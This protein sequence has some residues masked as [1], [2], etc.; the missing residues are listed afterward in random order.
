M[1]QMVSWTHIDRCRLGDLGEINLIMRLGVAQ[2]IFISIRSPSIHSNSLQFLNITI[3]SHF[4]IDTD[5]TVQWRRRVVDIEICN[6]CFDDFCKD[7]AVFLIMAN[8]YL[9]G[10]SWVE[11]LSHCWG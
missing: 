3:I 6:S 8:P 10:L 9:D 11:L 2:A 7:L 5:S 1:Y 4:K